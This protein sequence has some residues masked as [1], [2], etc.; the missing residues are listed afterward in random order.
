MIFDMVTVGMV[1]TNC[2]LIADETNNVGIVVDPG[3][4]PDRIMEMVNKAGVKIKYIVLTHGHY[5]HCGAMEEIKKRTGCNTVIVHREDEA[6]LEDPES[7]SSP[8]I[9]GRRLSYKADK[10]VEDGDIIK[11]GGIDITVKHTPGHTV[12]GISL[13][14]DNKC[15]CGDA[16]FAGSVGRTDLK[17]G[18]M[19]DLRYS[20]DKVFKKLPDEMEVW[21]GHGPSST[22]GRE[23]KVNPYM[24]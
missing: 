15:V 5:D 1:M 6:V 19:D 17:T 12:G 8:W 2:Y 9:A 3:A 23:K 14:F 7:N 4:E 21:P 20:L 11:V 16:L 10:L 22:I 24:K 13:I 18:S